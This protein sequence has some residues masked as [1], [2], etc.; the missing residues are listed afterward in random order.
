VTLPLLLACAPEHHRGRPLA[1]AVR[2][3]RA[4]AAVQ[5]GPGRVGAL[6]RRELGLVGLPHQPPSWE[7]WLGTTGQGQD[8]LAQTVVGARPTLA[9]GAVT[10]HRV[11]CHL[12]EPP[13]GRTP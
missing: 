6:A 3:L 13:D 10:G 7:H 1:H 2:G 11:R 4:D 8:V 5:L 12:H 9:V